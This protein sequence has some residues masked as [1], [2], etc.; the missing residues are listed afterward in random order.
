[1]YTILFLEGSLV[2]GP[3][4]KAPGRGLLGLVLGPDLSKAIEGK[5]SREK[6][7]YAGVP[8]S[9]S[10]IHWAPEFS[11]MHPSNASPYYLGKLHGRP[12]AGTW[13]WKYK[14]RT[15]CHKCQL[16]I[17]IFYWQYPSFLLSLLVESIYDKISWA[18]AKSIFRRIQAERDDFCKLWLLCC[19]P[20]E[21]AI[22]VAPKK[23]NMG[24][25]RKWC[26]CI[27]VYKMT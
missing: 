23:K 6:V 14:H 25:E 20:W 5:E 8:S 4:L 10:E 11:S 19:R 16:T 12:Q 2:L 1:M 3:N 26:S 15:W 21:L 22:S 18:L 27:A 13:Q 17:P 24:R 7:N 9:R